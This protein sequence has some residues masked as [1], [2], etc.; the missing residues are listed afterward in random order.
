MPRLKIYYKYNK[1]SNEPGKW[2]LSRK[3][4]A[5]SI[6]R[7]TFFF[8]GLGLEQETSNAILKS[9]T[10]AIQPRD[11]EGHDSYKDS[12]LFEEYSVP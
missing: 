1:Y 5:I 12:W 9:T 7:P 8:T 11:G 10:W 6:E 2:K 3:S 4:W